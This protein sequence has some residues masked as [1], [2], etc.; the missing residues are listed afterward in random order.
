[1]SR[2]RQ[3][4]M[5][6]VSMV[7]PITRHSENQRRRFNVYDNAW[8]ANNKVRTWCRNLNYLVTNNLNLRMRKE[9]ERVWDIRNRTKKFSTRIRALS[10]PRRNESAR[11]L[12]T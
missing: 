2:I 11:R 3:R 9:T 7:I 10:L 8:E 5:F 6:R 12:S 1:M 4:S